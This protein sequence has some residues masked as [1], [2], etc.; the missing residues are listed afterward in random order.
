MSTKLSDIG[1]KLNLIPAI[2]SFEPG[3]PTAQLPYETY[4]FFDKIKTPFPVNNPEKE[5]SKNYNLPT[6]Q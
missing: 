3:T 2:P 5:Y 4:S 1:A 6:Q